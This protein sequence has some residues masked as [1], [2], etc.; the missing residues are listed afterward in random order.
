MKKEIY[1]DSLILGSGVNE[2]S[3]Y[4]TSLTP[5][6]GYKL[7]SSSMDGY[8]LE[9]QDRSGKVEGFIPLSMT[10]NNLGDF[11]NKVVSVT[12]IVLKSQEYII[13]VE[14]IAEAK[15]YKPYDVILALSDEMRAKYEALLGKMVSSIVNEKYKALILGIYTKEH[16]K[17]MG[18]C[19]LSLK[20]YGNYCGAVLAATTTIANTALSM[21]SMFNSMGNGVYNTKI[22]RDIVLTACLL[23]YAGKVH[24]ISTFPFKRTNEAR[25]IGSVGVLQSLVFDT[26]RTKDLDMSMAEVSELLS[27]VIP[28]LNP[29]GQQKVIT[30]EA[31]IVKSATE[32]YMLCDM[33]DKAVCDYT[34]S[35]ELFYSPQLGQYCKNT[36][37]V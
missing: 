27:Y 9:L 4:L 35:E 21:V 12:G 5:A 1:A 3:F 19:P 10:P 25:Q 20:Q 13:K 31:S 16:V 17:K 34:G 2:Q 11:V 18:T 23:Q 15:D 36:K 14:A 22:D 33:K 32:A 37:A 6:K 24:E 7:Q 29:K 30:K 8:I 26:I 28:S